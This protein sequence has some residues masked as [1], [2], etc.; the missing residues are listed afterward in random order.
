MPSALKIEPISLRSQLV[1]QLR[2]AILR[3][4]FRPGQHLVERSLA[5]ESGTSQ[6]TVREALQVLSQE[7]LVFKKANTGTYVTELSVR[8]L[9]EIIDVRKALEPEAVW[10]ASRRMNGASKEKLRQ[11]ALEIQRQAREHDIYQSSRAD[12]HFHQFL[13]DAGGNEVLAQHL[14]QL[15]ASYFAYTSILPG[16]TEQD[17]DERF[18]SHDAFLRD[19]KAGV[20]DRYDRHMLLLNLIVEGDRSAI[21]TGVRE[22]IEEPWKWLFS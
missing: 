1:S 13:W 21:E 15:C 16:L 17:L 22:H 8:R 5:A 6:V 14:R 9:R 7:G 2:E 3:G 19:W 12:F 4:R 20:E 18:G 11:L 10:L